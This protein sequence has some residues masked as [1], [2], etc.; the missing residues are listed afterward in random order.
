[1]QKPL[2][3]R[4][5]E[6]GEVPVECTER[7]DPAGE[8][9]VEE[10]VDASPNWYWSP[11]RDPLRIIAGAKDL[12]ILLHSPAAHSLLP[13]SGEPRLYRRCVEPLVWPLRGTYIVQYW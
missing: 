6:E 2:C 4:R 11:D 12:D 7:N 1:M 3:V 13:V 10:G 5:C 8:T 9:E